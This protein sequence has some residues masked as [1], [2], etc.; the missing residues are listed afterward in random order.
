[1]LNNSASNIINKL[2]IESQ[3]LFVF[4]SDIITMIIDKFTKYFDNDL[5]NIKCC[6]ICCGN[7]E[8]INEFIKLKVKELVTKYLN[9]N[10]IDYH[11]ELFKELKTNY[12]SKKYSINQTKHSNLIICNLLNV[13]RNNELQIKVINNLIESLSYDKNICF[14]VIPEVLISDYERFNKIKKL[15]IGCQIMEIIQCNNTLFYPKYYQCDNVITNINSVNTNKDIITNL[16]DNVNRYCILIFRKY[17]L[18]E[19]H[20]F[21]VKVTNYYVDGYSVINDKRI[22]THKANVTIHNTYDFII[23]NWFDIVNKDIK[24]ELIHNE[25]LNSI[26]HYYKHKYNKGLIDYMIHEN[27]FNHQNGGRQNAKCKL[28]GGFIKS[29][30]EIKLRDVIEYV[31]VNTYDISC[32]NGI[33]PLISNIRDDNGILGYIDQF[34][35]GDISITISNKNPVICYYHNYPVAI[36]QSVRLF[37]I[38]DNLIDPHLL[39]ILINYYLINKDYQI[40]SVKEILGIV[41]Y[42]P[43]FY[44]SW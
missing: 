19:Y 22:K 29:W 39:T 4:P 31:R 27:L 1:M 40:I 13:T 43:I 8:F 38:K 6:D 25:V 21:N 7:Y 33:Y 23:T 5:S 3:K 10:L 2:Q 42:V 41:I 14:C 26:I 17:N 11:N 44:D 12:N 32:E 34:S 37:K 35:Y 15:L 28:N 16:N 18:I 20:K 24:I 9:K 30:K 36:D